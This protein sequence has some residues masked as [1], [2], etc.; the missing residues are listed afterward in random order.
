MQLIK[1]NCR[2]AIYST[3][4]V[5]LKGEVFN[6]SKPFRSF[7]LKFNNI[8]IL[9]VK[10]SKNLHDLHAQALMVVEDVQLTHS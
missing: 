10:C 7:Q 3:F 8:R 9:L 2:N 1:A 4:N 6:N 5:S